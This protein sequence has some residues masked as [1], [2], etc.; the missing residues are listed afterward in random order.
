MEGNVSSNL[1]DKIKYKLKAVSIHFFLSLIIFAVILYFILYEW[2][3]EPF[4]TAQ[5]GWQGIRLMAFVDLVLGPSLTLIVFNHLKS[6]KEILF[7]LSII[8][9]VQIT[10]LVLGGYTVYTERPIAL[11]YW[12][13]EFYTVTENDYQMQG[14][15]SPDFSQYSTNVPPLIYSRPVATQDELDISKALTKKLI[16]AYAHVDFYEKT[17]DYLEYIFSNE[18]DMNEVILA[19]SE[20]LD[21]IEEITKGELE[22]YKYIA[23]KAKFHNMILIMKEDGVLIGSVKA[24]SRS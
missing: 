5:G 21:R 11:V 10:A 16:P 8:A 17:E 3:P 13:T 23:L 19:N 4:F 20:M 12:A 18:I 24:P 1:I 7:D 14:I 22:A 15:D 9:S 2:Y 6:R